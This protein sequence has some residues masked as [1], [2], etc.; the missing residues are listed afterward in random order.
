MLLLFDKNAYCK[1]LKMFDD[2]PKNAENWGC[3]CYEPTPTTPKFLNL[4]FHS[5]SPA[6]NRSLK[7]KCKCNEL[8]PY[9][10]MSKSLTSTADAKGFGG[11]R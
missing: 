6:E 2:E 10:T 8:P 3:M 11:A 4:C 1:V 7:S 5:I 9:Q